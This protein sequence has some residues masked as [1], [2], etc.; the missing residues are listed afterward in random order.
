MTSRHAMERKWSRFFPNRRSRYPTIASPSCTF[1]PVSPLYCS[2]SNNGI[3]EG[4][5]VTSPF[6]PTGKVDA[7]ERIPQIWDGVD[8]APHLDPRLGSQSIVMTAKG[9]CLVVNACMKHTTTAPARM[10][11]RER[12]FLDDQNPAAISPA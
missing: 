10:P 6:R 3:A 1:A 7:K 9:S 5:T 12:L 11:A 2:C 8:I 4:P